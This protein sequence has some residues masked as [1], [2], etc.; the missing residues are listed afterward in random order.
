MRDIGFSKGFRWAAALVL[1]TLVVALA[2]R[3]GGAWASPSTDVNRQTVPTA[4]PSPTPIPSPTPEEEGFVDVT[5]TGDAEPGGELAMTVRVCCTLDETMEQARLVLGDVEG[6]TFSNIQVD[7]GSAEG[8]SIVWNVG[9]L[10]VG[11][12]CTLTA[13][14][15]IGEDVMP[16]AILRLGVDL[17]WGEA[18]QA[19]EDEMLYMPGAIL[20]DTG[21]W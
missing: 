21:G 17:T 15:T 4:V 16:D 19:S 12:C 6:L 18:G 2:G 10:P 9:D 8:G 20:P 11:E 1:L 14:A 3:G 13:V 5:F 7:C